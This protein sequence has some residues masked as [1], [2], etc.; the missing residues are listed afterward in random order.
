MAELIHVPGNK[1]MLG[2]V[3]QDMKR[4][5]TEDPNLQRDR[6]MITRTAPFSFPERSKTN[7]TRAIVNGTDVYYRIFQ[8][9]HVWAY[10]GVW[11]AW[12]TPIIFRLDQTNGADGKTLPTGL[13]II[14][15]FHQTI[16]CCRLFFDQEWPTHDHT[17]QQQQAHNAELERLRRSKVEGFKPRSHKL[18]DGAI[19]NQRRDLEQQVGEA[20]TGLLQG[21]S[22]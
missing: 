14:I 21:L 7:L 15:L 16:Q 18:Y 22:H 1:H 12:T 17:R 11:L 13:I 3:R 9:G 2:N 19:L 6:R 4:E 8:G 20:S 5:F 10:V